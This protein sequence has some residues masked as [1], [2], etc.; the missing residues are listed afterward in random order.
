MGGEVLG[1]VLENYGVTGLTMFILSLM[2]LTLFIKFI[3]TKLFHMKFPWPIT[4]EIPID[5][6]LKDHLFFTNARFKL[7]FDIPSLELVP[8]K[9]TIQ[10]MYRDLI[11]LNVES[12]Y[13]GCKRLIE[14]N[15]I[16]AMSGTEWGAT[17]NRELHRM[18]RSYE[19][20]AEDFGVPSVIVARYAQWL[21][22]YIAML[23]NY[24][25]QLSSA[26]VYGNSVL[27]TNVFLLVMNLLIVTMI[28]DI[29]KLARDTQDSGLEYRGSLLEDS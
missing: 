21:G 23:A 9:P 3:T 29:G 14:T 4:N 5:S 2:A 24:I 11:Y 16:S 18:L 10:R 26:P 27:R 25:E 20:K 12:F 15:D 19:E 28:G 1:V 6:T 22:A 17:V 7:R 8:E 13:H